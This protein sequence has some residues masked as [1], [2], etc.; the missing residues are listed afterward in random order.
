MNHPTAFDWYMSDGKAGLQW[1]EV[2]AVQEEWVPID[3][4]LEVFVR[5]NDYLNKEVGRVNIRDALENISVDVDNTGIFN[6]VAQKNK[7]DAT[8]SGLANSASGVTSPEELAEMARYI[9]GYNDEIEKMKC[10][11]MFAPSIHE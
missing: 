2:D 6:N 1:G 7:I 8:A 4:N 9:S 11:N 5:I 3:E 10:D